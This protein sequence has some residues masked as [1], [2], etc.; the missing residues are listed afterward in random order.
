MK[1]TTLAGYVPAVGKRSNTNI[2]IL[3]T[4]RASLGSPFDSAILQ[5]MSDGLEQ[6]GYDLLVLSARS[7]LPAETWAQF[8]L[9]KGVIGAVVRTDEQTRGICREIVD[10]GV[11]T[12]VLADEF[13]DTAIQTLCIDSRKATRQAIEHL[14]HLGHT[15]IAITLNVV[16]DHDHRQRLESYTTVLTENG[17][18]PAE[19]YVLRVPAV[20]DSGAVALRQIMGMPNRPSAV[21]VTDPLAAVGIFFEAQK[22]GVKIPRDLSIVGF[23]DSQQRLGV[24]PRMSAVCQ[25]AEQLGV[26]VISAMHRLID[27]SEDRPVAGNLECW[28]ELHESTA[29]PFAA[30]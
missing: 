22:A 6:H 12:L 20:R 25:D 5:G 17:I 7:K 9:R 30:D 19:R 28:L 11:P 10:G 18:E 26:Q 21:Y 3:Y 8:F 2:A 29:G 1:A 23:D 27:G 24:Y 4:G 13:E 16:D 14:V 15:R